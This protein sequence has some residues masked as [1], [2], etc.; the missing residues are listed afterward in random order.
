MP[1]GIN[2]MTSRGLTKE[3]LNAMDTEHGGLTYYVD[4]NGK[5][6]QTTDGAAP[7]GAQFTMT[8]C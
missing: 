4:A 8:V 5:G 6:V 3:S 7:A 2:W 1:T